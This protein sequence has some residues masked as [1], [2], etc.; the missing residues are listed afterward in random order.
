MSKQ[1]F[2]QNLAGKA[3]TINVNDSDRVE[4]IKRKIQAKEFIPA[5]KQRLV[6]SGKEMIDG[7]TLGDYNV[8][9]DSTVHM[10]IR[11]KGGA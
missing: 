2:V 7:Q 10:A 11:M 9:K 4:D 3:I 5:D 8:V 1:I 6:Y